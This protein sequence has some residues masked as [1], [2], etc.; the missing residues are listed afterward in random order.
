MPLTSRG[1]LGNKSAI[2]VT[3]SS[4]P[5]TITFLSSESSHHQILVLRL[6]LQDQ[7]SVLKKELHDLDVQYSKKTVSYINNGS[8]CD[9]NEDGAGR[10]LW[11]FCNLKIPMFLRD[12]KQYMHY[13]E[14][15]CETKTCSKGFIAHCSWRVPRA[16]SQRSREIH[17]TAAAG[18]S[19][20]RFQVRLLHGPSRFEVA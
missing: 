10:Y 12:F 11:C 4:Q 13:Y 6:S 7:L 2:E 17:L 15:R 19:S 14:S 1:N 18:S 9:D 20:F 8:C 5:P 3:Q 16:P